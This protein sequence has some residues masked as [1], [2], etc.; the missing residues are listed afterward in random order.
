MSTEA[1]LATSVIDTHE[2]QHIL[3]LGI[4]NTFVQIPIPSS[5]E[6]IIMQNTGKL[7]TFLVEL[8]PK[9]YE[10]Y[11]KHTNNIPVIYIMKKAL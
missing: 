8:F 9:K 2:N 5:E 3:T 7:V 6:R 11:V 1:L 10:R 4:P